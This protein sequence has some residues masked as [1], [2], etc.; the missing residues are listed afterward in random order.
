MI[1]DPV[2]EGNGLVGRIIE[3]SSTRSTMLRQVLEYVT[4]DR[5]LLVLL[6]VIILTMNY[7]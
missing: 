4:L 2:I 3:I 7:L 1:G 6:K 5:A